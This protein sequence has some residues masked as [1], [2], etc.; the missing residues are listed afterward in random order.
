MWRTGHCILNEWTNFSY[1]LPSSSHTFSGMKIYTQLRL[2]NSR[3][4]PIGQLKEGTGNKS[5]LDW[6]ISTKKKVVQ[7]TGPA[8]NNNRWW[9]DLR[10]PPGWLCTTLVHA[11]FSRSTKHVMSC[12]KKPHTLDQHSWVHGCFSW[13]PCEALMLLPF[14]FTNCSPRTKSLMHRQAIILERPNSAVP[15]CGYDHSTP[16]V[17]CALWTVPQELVLRLVQ[18]CTDRARWQHF[19]WPSCCRPFARGLGEQL[20]VQTENTRSRGSW[21]TAVSGR[22]VST[23][24]WSILEL[25][26][27][28]Q[29]NMASWFYANPGYRDGCIVGLEALWWICGFCLSPYRFILVLTVP[30]I[31]IGVFTSRHY[32]L[33]IRSEW[34][35]HLAR[36][37]SKSWWFRNTMSLESI[38]SSNE[39]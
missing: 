1:I 13:C 35:R 18:I 9:R 33:P 8:T 34:C 4:I 38:G 26:L 24:T 3:G 28:G 20:L 10:G 7:A 23:A 12:T 27:R 21:R 16:G 17:W 5:D 22:T 32:M 36:T 31:N 29:W 19:L 39:F 15:S 30:N 2:T 11:Q 37:T 6:K 14:T 25:H